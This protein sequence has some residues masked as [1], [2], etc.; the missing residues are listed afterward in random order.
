MANASYDEMAT[1]EL[2]QNTLS[3]LNNMNIKVIFV[4]FWFEF[5]LESSFSMY[6]MNGL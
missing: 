2:Q 1:P 5:M 6:R 3:D 4:A